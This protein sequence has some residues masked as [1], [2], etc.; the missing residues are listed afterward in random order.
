MHE[1]VTPQ[2][3]SKLFSI[4]KTLTIASL[5]KIYGPQIIPKRQHT[6]P[7]KALPQIRLLSP[8]KLRR[9]LLPRGC[10]GAQGTHFCLRCLLCGARMRPSSKRSTNILSLCIS[11]PWQHQKTAW[12]VGCSFPC[13]PTNHTNK[14]QFKLIRQGSGQLPPQQH[15]HY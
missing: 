13:L 8:G 7:T 2:D 5:L 14:S 1:I 15:I 10:T 6:L 3:K 4:M 9:L 12:G 11:A